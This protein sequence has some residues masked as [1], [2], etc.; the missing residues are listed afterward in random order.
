MCQNIIEPPEIKEIFDKPGSAWSPEETYIVLGWMFRIEPLPD[1]KYKEDNKTWPNPNYNVRMRC[2]LKLALWNLGRGA[3]PEDAEDALTGFCT[4]EPPPKKEPPPKEEDAERTNAAKE[5][6]PPKKEDA[7]NTN[8]E[9]T[10][11]KV[12]AG[13]P[14]S[15]DGVIKS[16]DP[17]KGPR[18]WEYLKLCFKRHCWQEARRLGRRLRTEIPLEDYEQANN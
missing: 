16:Y 2:L 14:S 5:E 15:L 3:Q 6:S 7:K 10:S 13:R 8:S 1:S 9:D 12:D 18:F 11:A 4:G 17:G